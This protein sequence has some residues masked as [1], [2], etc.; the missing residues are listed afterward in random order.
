MPPFVVIREEKKVRAMTRPASTL[1]C[2][3]SNIKYHVGWHSVNLEPAWYWKKL[4]NFSFEGKI[5]WGERA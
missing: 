4:K 2:L 3:L 5:E 1:E